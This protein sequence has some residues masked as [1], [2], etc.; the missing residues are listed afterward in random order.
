MP[1]PLPEPAPGWRTRATCGRMPQAVRLFTDPGGRDLETARLICAT[2]PVRID[3]YADAYTRPADTTTIR[4]GTRPQDRP[5]KAS[6]H[7]YTCPCG[8]PTS[9]KPPHRCAACTPAGRP[10][11]LELI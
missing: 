7:H 3:C 8:L 4:A 9:R 1:G 2:C 6:S 5:T 11:I 10:T